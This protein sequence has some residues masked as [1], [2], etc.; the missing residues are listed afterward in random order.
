MS[1]KLYHHD[2]FLDEVN[3]VD[4]YGINN[5]KLELIKKAFPDVKIIAR[6]STIKTVGELQKI[7][8][9][10]KIINGILNE[11]KTYG[12]VDAFRVID[13]INRVPF[14]E[15]SSKNEPPDVILRGVNGNLI[16]PKTPG[17]RR[18]VKVAAECELVF[19]IGPAGSGKTYTAVALA[20]R[21]LRDKLVKKIVLVRPAVEAGE[22]L[23]FLPGDLKDK[24]D[25]YLRPLY[26]SL[27]DMILPEKLQSYLEK[28][29]IEIVPLAYMRGRTLNNSFI[30]LDEAQNATESQMKML[31]T[32]MGYDSRIIVTGDTTQIDLPKSQKSGLIQCTRILKNIAGIEFVF[33]TEEDVVR[34]QLVKKILAAYA[35]DEKAQSQEYAQ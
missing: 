33:L 1:Q 5:E 23:G 19:A 15:V 18:L 24:I 31:L 7:E 21:A 11:I 22:K 28:N 8:A 17:Q 20:V 13:I 26:D 27:E 29:I 25:P 2:I 32:R 4:F 12:E 14:S 9:I 35:E 3:P 6:G 10:H 30:I 34:H 16:R